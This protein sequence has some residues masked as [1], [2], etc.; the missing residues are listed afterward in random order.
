MRLVPM[1]RIETDRLILRKFRMSDLEAHYRHITSDPEVAKTMLWQANPDIAHARTVLTR[2]L[3]GYDTPGTYRWAI[4][5]KEDDAFLGT[6][7]LLRLD[8]TEKSCSFAYMLGRAFWNRGYMTEALTAVLDFAFGQIGVERVETDHFADNP[9]SGAVMEKAGMKRAGVLPGR[10][11]KD[12]VIHDAVLYRIT[13][14]DWCGRE[15]QP[16]FRRKS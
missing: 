15:N 8:E 9:A 1:G 11:E 5:R 14:E 16:H 6:V 4:V 12:G 2:I 7:S 10:Y 3:A 13:K